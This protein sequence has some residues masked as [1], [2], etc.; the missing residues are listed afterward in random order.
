VT[1]TSGCQATELAK[2]TD[3]I[4][5]AQVKQPALVLGGQPRGRHDG[6]SRQADDDLKRIIQTANTEKI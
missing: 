5:I 6:Q 4:T 3:T 1:E 2:P